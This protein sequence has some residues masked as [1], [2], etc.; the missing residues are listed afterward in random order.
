MHEYVRCMLLKPPA[1]MQ[2]WKCSKTCC[3][4]LHRLMD[5]EHFAQS[6]TKDGLENKSLNVNKNVTCNNVS[7]TIYRLKFHIYHLEVFEI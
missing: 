2:V 7:K 4:L 3:D 1:N 5:N 6:L